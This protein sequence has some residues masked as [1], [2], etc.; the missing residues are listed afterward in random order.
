VRQALLPYARLSWARAA[1]FWQAGPGCGARL[2]IVAGGG[3]ERLPL[4]SQPKKR[5]VDRRKAEFGWR[6]APTDV[7]LEPKDDDFGFKTGP[8][9]ERQ[10]HDMKQQTEK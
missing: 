9:S 3:A 5:L 10:G 6:P 2:D 7:E 8:R 1:R 4:W